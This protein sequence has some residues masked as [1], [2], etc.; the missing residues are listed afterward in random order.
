MKLYQING[1]VFGS[2]GKIMFGIA[3]AAGRQGHQ[4]RCASPVTS[5]NR[6]RQPAQAY[7]QIGTYY[8]RR[9]SVALARITG[10]EGCFG[11]FATKRLIAD[12]KRF[13]P[14]LVQLHNI[15][16]SYL[17]LPMLFRYIQKHH[18]PVV[19]TLHD[20]WAFTGH[21][22]YF[23]IVQCE[24]WRSG[25]KGCPQYKEY[26]QSLFDNAAGMYRRKKALFTGV[27]DLT[28]VTPSQWL[29]ELAKQSFLGKYPVQALPNGIDL[30]VFKPGSSDFREKYGCRHQYILLGVAFGWD[31]RKGLD[32][33]VELAKR[34][35]DTYRIVL[36]GTDDRVDAQLPQ[37]I[38][39]IHRTTNQ[40]EL[41]EIYA[42]ADLLVNPTR[43]ENYPTVN[44]EAIACGTPVLTFATG[45][46]PEIP[47]ELSGA[48]VPK[49][50]VAALVEKIQMIRQQPFRAEDL[51]ARAACFDQNDRFMDY[52]RLYEEIMR[53]RS[54]RC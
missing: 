13:Q 10:A 52:V 22:P 26:P 43:E 2:T 32:V 35:D 8:G 29:A 54:A 51:A 50:D 12:M 27:K 33:F 41:A 53:E 17:N 9:I 47:D 21:C 3:D 19:W 5:T 24:K 49:D 44:M 1:G 20:C 7:H 46:S 45:G 37:S 36:V 11:W 34:L 16:G 15:H 31:R 39:S 18:I 28:I 25:C 40:Q 14:D 48:V 30:S 23:D 6:T 38:I 4:V 42:A